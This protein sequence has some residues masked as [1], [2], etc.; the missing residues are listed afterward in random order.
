MEPTFH[1]G[2]RL[3]INKWAYALSKP[4][5]GDVVVFKYPPDNKRDFIK[6][7]V[8][9]PNETVE[10]K[11]GDVYID[12]REV[13]DNGVI[14]D[15]YYYSKADLPYGRSGEPVNVPEGSYFVLGDNSANSSDSRTWGFVPRQNMVGRAFFVYWPPN[16]IKRIR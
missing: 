11:G 10:I 15:T 4:R 3:L 6:R 14:R 7:L 1:E 13:K 12:D 2:D 16:R 8:A 9:G 5:V